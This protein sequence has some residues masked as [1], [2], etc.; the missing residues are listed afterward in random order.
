MEIGTGKLTA[1]TFGSPLILPRRWYAIELETNIEDSSAGVT[2]VYVD[3]A[4]Y[5]TVTGLTQAPSIQGTLGV[6][7]ALATTTGTIL[8]D[9]FVFDDARVFPSER[10]PNVCT[11]TQDAHVFVGPGN[12]DAAALMTTGGSEILTLWDT[13]RAVADATQGFKV[14]LTDG[15]QTAFTGPLF[16]QRGCYAVISGTD[17]RAQVI[18]T[19][20]SDRP[21]V[22]G[23]KT[24]SPSG[25]R[26]WGRAN[27]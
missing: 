3:Q 26:N 11:I 7:D 24:R 2:T 18:L 20:S 1:T 16:F 17:A 9:Q 27:S 8:F 4:Q 23:P 6:N 21:G 12:I 14:Q 5:A 10:F 19:S 15:V 13:D 22:L 25:M